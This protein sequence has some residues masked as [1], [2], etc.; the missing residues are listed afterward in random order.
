MNAGIIST[1]RMSQAFKGN[2]IYMIISEL[3]EEEQNKL[4]PF[5]TW[6]TE[7]LKQNDH[8]QNFY[9]LTQICPDM[10]IEK[11]L[12]ALLACNFSVMF[13]VFLDNPW[14]IFLHKKPPNI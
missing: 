14:F 8:N 13:W 7:D 9:L 5:E 2:F 3:H 1:C 4:Y 12:R 10:C 11:C 6:K